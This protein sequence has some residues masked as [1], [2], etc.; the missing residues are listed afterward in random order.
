MVFISCNKT[1][2]KHIFNTIEIDKNNRTITFE[3]KLNLTNNEKYFL[4]YFQGYPWI[5]DYCIFVSSCELK[6]LQV[7]V[8]LIDWELWDKIYTKKFSPHLEIKF[9]EDDKWLNLFEYIELKNFN[10]Y[11]TIFW[12]N[13]LYDE[14][15]LKNT[16]NNNFICQSCNFLPLEQSNILTGTTSLN[17]KFTKKFKKDNFKIKIKFK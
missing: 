15:V 12:G 5:K 14:L 3:A 10:S 16:Y 17:Y 9:L 4:F 13:P 1:K 2:Q 6:D 7:A 8:A 11:Q